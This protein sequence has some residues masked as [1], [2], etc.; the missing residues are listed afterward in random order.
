MT[1]NIRLGI[2]SDCI[3]YKSTDGRIGTENHILLKQLSEL[4]K[5]FHQTTICCPFENFDPNRSISFYDK[6]DIHFISVPQVGGNTLKEKF[7]LFSVLPK[8]ITAFKKINKTSDVVYQRFPN[9]LNIPG[10][11]YFWLKRKKAFA[12]YTGTWN[13]YAGEPVTY[14]FQ[15]WILRNLFRGPVWVYSQTSDINDEKIHA[16]FSPSYSLQVYDEEAEQIRERIENITTIGIP[17]LRLITVGTLI[18]YKNQELIIRACKKLKENAIHFTLAIVGDGA[19]KEYLQTLVHDLGLAME[20]IFAGR[21]NDSE[22]RAMYRQADFVVQAPLT[23][24][25]GKVPIEGFF[26]GVIPIISD[27]A[28]A[29][30]M[31]GQDERGFIFNANDERSLVDT[32]MNLQISLSGFPGMIE[33]G[34]TFA[35]NQTLEA[36]AKDYADTVKNY[37]EKR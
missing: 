37:F 36:W 23:E 10:F 18:H 20:I 21:K 34:R 3:H 19:Q 22:L 9:N 25:F 28:M 5:H 1:D 26:H 16:G 2:I 15:R 29:L 8:W 35:K 17:V 7:K 27:T 4:A 12:T 31:I 33:K 24:G 32:L 11:F 6:S 14:Q 30:Y 13:G